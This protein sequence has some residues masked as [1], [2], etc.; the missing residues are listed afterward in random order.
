VG[1]PLPELILNA[2]ARVVERYGLPWYKRA[3]FAV[4]SRPR[5][6]DAAAR[7]ASLVQ[8]P[9]VAADGFLR[10]PL[11]ESLAWRSVPALA[12]HPARDY[13]MGRTFEGDST[14]P[15]AHSNARGLTVAYF[16]QCVADRAA[17]EQID[18]A[19]RVLRACGVRV[20]VP[21]GQHCCGLPALD[22]GDHATARRMARQTIDALEAS[23]ADYVVTGAASCGIAIAHDFAR[24]FRDEPAWAERAERLARR[25]LDLLTF[26]DS[27]A[28]PPVLEALQ[29]PPVTYHSFC[30]ST[31]ILGISALGPRLLRRAGVP[32]ADLPEMEVCCGF[33]GGASV[34]YPEVS[35]GIVTR[36]LDNVA[37]TGAAILC[38]DNPGCAL[39]L[40]GAAHARGMDLTV[41]HVAEVL[42]DALNAVSPP[43]G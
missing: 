9:V 8:L 31:N 34:D 17:P 35:R 22:A 28:D 11:P 2:R 37:A 16:L 25:T 29:R 39:H 18:A 41:R 38:T 6:F 3:A 19:V 5:I 24:L 21:E 33:G 23:N 15:W 40:K 20:V 14:G 30:Q 4:W 42:A 43:L 7:F 1:I 27:V 26:V 12:R 10:L 32:L 13:A 36:K